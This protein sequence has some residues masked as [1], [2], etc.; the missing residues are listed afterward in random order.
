M[1]KETIKCFI[2]G[3]NS[4]KPTQNKVNTL[5][6]IHAPFKLCDATPNAMGLDNHII[7]SITKWE[8]IKLQKN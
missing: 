3:C 1:I 2:C 4:Y 5:F 6:M 8:I 7:H